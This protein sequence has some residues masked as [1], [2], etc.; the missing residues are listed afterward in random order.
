M[1]RGAAWMMAVRWC[2]RGLDVILLVILARLLTPEDFGIFA[3]AALI[4]GFLEILSQAGID[5]ALIRDRSATK[6]HFHAAWT[7]QLIQGFGVAAL[8][9]AFA[10]LI[11]GFFDDPRLATLLRFLALRPAIQG[12]TNIGVVNFLRDLQFHRE[13]RFG[14]VKKLGTFAVTLA[15]AFTS[16]DYT[17]LLWGALLGAAI[18]V[19]ASYVMHP[20]RPRWCVREIG[21]IWNFSIWILVYYAMEDLVEKLDRFVVGRVAQVATLGQF[22]LGSQVA[23]L[24]LEALVTPLWRALVPAYS[25]LNHDLDA[26]RDTYLKV[27]G[28]TATLGLCAGFGM[29]AVADDLVLVMLGAQWA[30]AGQIAGT[31]ALVPALAGLVDSAMMVVSVTGQ[32]RLCGLHSCVRLIVLAAVLPWLGFNFGIAEVAQGYLVCSVLLLP[33]PFY[34]LS[35]IVPLG[36]GDVARQLWRPVSA[37]LAML[38]TLEIVGTG[39]STDAVLSL[40]AGVVTGATV[41]IAVLA[42]LWLL[43]GRPAGPESAAWAYIVERGRN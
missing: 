34:L 21:G 43:A 3:I 24:P 35:R 42:G 29:A 2:V 14:L 19:V 39:D 4:V 30:L 11:A 9:M 12:L 15:F 31:L 8:L 18:G 6:Q 33:L 26:L 17:A 28:V 1:A 16:R 37:G 38:L 25:T 40:A 41:Y 27:L 36:F 20:F 7:V 10:P 13:F 22:H 23:H 32:S 5:I